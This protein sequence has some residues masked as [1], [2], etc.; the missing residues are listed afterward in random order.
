MVNSFHESFDWRALLK[1][2][3]RL[4]KL[5]QPEVARRAQISLS[6]MKAYEGGD[7]H[8]SRETLQAITVALGLP[9]EETNRVLAGAGYAIDMRHVLNERYEPRPLEWF[10]EEVE[11]YAWPVFV[12]NQA[13]AALAANRAGRKLLGIPL[14]DRL[15]QPKWSFMARASDP[16]FASRVEN[17]DEVM[18]FILGI[19]KGE[20][21][22][23]ANLERMPPPVIEPF[24]QFLGGDP[25][26]ITRLLKLWETAAPIEIST[27]MAGPVRWR[28]ESGELL[29]FTGMMHVADLWQELAWLDWVP[30]DEPTWA[31][32]RQQ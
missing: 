1:E 24:Q 22:F 11:R 16:A 19:L 31:L 18:G 28:A 23:E 10:T 8:P 9:V 20:Q 14:T 15:P 27:R 4:K 30:D 6:A 12:T 2:Q 17:W 25:A 21:R 7:R 32:L 29:S 26:Y 3:R 5:S 13:S